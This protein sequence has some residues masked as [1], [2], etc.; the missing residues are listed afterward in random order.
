MPFPQENE[1]YTYA[2]Y[3]TWDVKW[4]VKKSYINP[5]LILMLNKVSR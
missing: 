5:F 3:C 1:R 2:D 4:N